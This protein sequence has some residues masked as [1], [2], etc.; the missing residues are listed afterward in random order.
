MKVQVTQVYEYEI[1][2]DLE[3]RRKSYGTIDPQEWEIV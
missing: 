2:D 1:P 3:L